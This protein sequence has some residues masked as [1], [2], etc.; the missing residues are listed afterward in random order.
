VGVHWTSNAPKVS[1]YPPVLMDLAQ[2]STSTSMER[3]L[4]LLFW[5][6]IAASVLRNAMG[7]GVPSPF[8]LAPMLHSVLM[9]YQV[10]FE[11]LVPMP[12]CG[13]QILGLHSF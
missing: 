1:P 11:P 6:G 10:P 9:P 2:V 7:F 5:R 8:V 4:V 12:L 13:P 3:K